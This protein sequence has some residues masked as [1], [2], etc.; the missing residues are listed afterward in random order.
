MPT[1]LELYRPA[2][3]EVAGSRL[4]LKK[5]APE[6]Q[7]AWDDFASK[8][9]IASAEFLER[10]GRIFANTKEYGW[11]EWDGNTWRRADK[12]G[13]KTGPR[14]GR[15]QRTNYADPHPRRQ[16]DDLHDVFSTDFSGYQRNIT[17]ACNKL[18]GKQWPQDIDAAYGQGST[19][20][21]LSDLWRNFWTD[22]EAL[23]EVGHYYDAAMQGQEGQYNLQIGP[24]FDQPRDYDTSAPDSL[25]PYENDDW[26]RRE[27]QFDAGYFD[28][29]WSS[30]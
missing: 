19:K 7:V 29:V 4:D 20:K 22:H 5:F 9:G 3:Q 30:S 15:W 12:P 16:T 1:L 17:Q 24:R 28:T 6:I 10:S 2:L 25:A 18:F 26:V 11:F 21:M 14:T 23:G 13:P 27:R 8:E